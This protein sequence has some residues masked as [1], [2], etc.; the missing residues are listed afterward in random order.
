MLPVHPDPLNA[1]I[2]PLQAINYV[3]FKDL[4]KDLKLIGEVCKKK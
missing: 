3:E 1:A 4:R 2:D